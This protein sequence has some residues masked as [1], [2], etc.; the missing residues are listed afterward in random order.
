MVN[1]LPDDNKSAEQAER[2]A[3]ARAKNQ[4][5]GDLTTPNVMPSA[6]TYSPP[7]ARLARGGSQQSSQNTK[8]SE[9]PI[10][11]PE[12]IRQNFAELSKMAD[13]PSNN[14]V[15]PTNTKLTEPAKM[16]ASA[17][18]AKPIAGPDITTKKPSMFDFVKNIFK[19][20]DAV[21]STIVADNKDEALNVNL[22]PEQ[23][24]QASE[25]KE[26]LIF[27][28]ALAGSAIILIVAGWGAF[29]LLTKAKLAERQQYEEQIKN[30]NQAV[31]DLKKQIQESSSK[32]RQVLAVQQILSARRNFLAFLDELQKQTMSVVTFDAL[33]LSDT[34]SLSLMAKAPTLE[35]ATKQYNIFKNSPDLFVSALVTQFSEK[36]KTGTDAKSGVTFPLTLTINK[37]VFA[38]PLF[39]YLN[40]SVAPVSTPTTPLSEPA[41]GLGTTSPSTGVGTTLPSSTSQ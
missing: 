6:P 28:V 2:E 19:K 17:P 23:F 33:S 39:P 8:L 4:T 32:G 22:L 29:S 30:E 31:A 21:A 9:P 41:T 36:D 5:A 14:K 37:D 25:I 16:P 1:F 3:V 20:K 27:L 38:K 18:T 11:A 24:Q 15:A 35:D 40:T 12:P 10:K 13:S 26:K 34:D 7:E